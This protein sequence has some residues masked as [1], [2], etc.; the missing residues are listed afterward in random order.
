M[1]A[2]Q[3]VTLLGLENRVSRMVSRLLAAGELE[4]RPCAED[5]REITRP[6]GGHDTVAKI[7]A[8]RWWRR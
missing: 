6:D 8:V 5:A 7:N 2:A 3:L 4:E 1:T